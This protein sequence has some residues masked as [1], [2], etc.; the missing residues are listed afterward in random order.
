MTV[1]VFIGL[2][3][4]SKD[5]KGVINKNLFV[6]PVSSDYRDTYAAQGKIFRI[7]AL[8]TLAVVSAMT[9]RM[10]LKLQEIFSLLGRGVLTDFRGVRARKRR[11]CAEVAEEMALTQLWRR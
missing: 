11:A 3:R 1:I 9:A 10:L 8:H 5:N 4:M 2:S 6:L 7:S